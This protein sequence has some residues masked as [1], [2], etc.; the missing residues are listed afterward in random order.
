MAKVTVYEDAHRSVGGVMSKVH[1]IVCPLD[2]QM[3]LLKQFESFTYISRK[4][5]EYSQQHVIWNYKHI[6][7][8]LLKSSK[9]VYNLYNREDGYFVEEDGPH[10]HLIEWLQF[11]LASFASTEYIYSV[12]RGLPAYTVNRGLSMRNPLSDHHDPSAQIRFSITTPHSH[13]DQVRKAINQMLDF[14]SIVGS[15]DHIREFE[16]HLIKTTSTMYITTF[17]LMIYTNMKQLLPASTIIDITAFKNRYDVF[18]EI[19]PFKSN[20]VGET[21]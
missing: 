19:P 4:A 5:F 17:E 20:P 6:N 8:L 18:N 9:N 1:H 3:T 16:T 7:T 2:P 10:E 13:K 14:G 21:Q 15:D 11:E 12:L